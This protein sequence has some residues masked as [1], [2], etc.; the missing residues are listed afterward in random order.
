MLKQRSSIDSIDIDKLKHLSNNEVVK[1][2]L[3]KYFIDKGFEDS[4]EKQL[5]PPMLQ[6]LTSTIPLIASKIE[7]VPFAKEIDTALNKAVLGWN[8]FVLGNQRMYLGETHHTG[9][10]DL[11][12]QI[13][14]G[15]IARSE[16]GGSI[17][18][19]KTTTPRK[20]ILFI[21][22]V[23]GN[24]EAGYVDLNL[25]NVPF[26]QPGEPYAAKQSLSGMPQQFF[27]RSGYGT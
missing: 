11:A 18:A 4:F 23:L 13:R 1:R 15:T 20:V 6:D 17:T 26:R 27:T 5:F 7:V 22:K 16:L 21:S 3:I 14:S 2:M 12:R 8:L 25:T 24:N 9:L 10:S 19:R